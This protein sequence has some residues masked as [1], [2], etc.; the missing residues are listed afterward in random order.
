MIVSFHQVNGW[1]WCDGLMGLIFPIFGEGDFF[2]NIF[3]IVSEGVGGVYV[4][5]DNYLQV[6]N[7]STKILF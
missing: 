7:F 4:T 2:I 1:Y 6:I 3:S 5:E